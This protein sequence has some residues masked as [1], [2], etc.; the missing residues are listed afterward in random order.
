[1]EN[2]LGRVIDDGGVV[3]YEHAKYKKQRARRGR[4]ARLWQQLPSGPNAMHE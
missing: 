4:E 1:M 2:R 3:E